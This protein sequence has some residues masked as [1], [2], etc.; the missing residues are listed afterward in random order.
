ML[1]LLLKRTTDKFLKKEE[2][3]E[4]EKEW[5][6]TLWSL[7]KVVWRISAVNCWHWPLSTLSSQALHFCHTVGRHNHRLP[8][9]Y[10]TVPHEW[11]NVSSVSP[12]AAG[13]TLTYRTFLAAP[14][15]CQV[16]P[17]RHHEVPVQVRQDHQLW[18]LQEWGFSFSPQWEHACVPPSTPR[19]NNFQRP[20]PFIMD[21]RGRWREA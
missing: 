12:L 14:A 4:E 20:A 21:L 7:W 15:H 3:M 9:Y 6:R 1:S 13:S 19:C 2:E 16:S 17:P 8:S 5:E 11:M 18:V 10:L